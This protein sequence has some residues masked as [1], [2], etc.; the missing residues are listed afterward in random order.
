MMRV[1]GMMRVR[2]E[3]RWIRAAV[4]SILP[5]CERVLILDDHSEDGTPEICRSLGQR[6][7]VIPSPFD[8]L[9]ESRDKNYLLT[10]IGKLGAAWCLCIDGDEILAPDGS[11]RILAALE[12]ARHDCYALRI[13]FL[14]NGP[15]VVRVDGVYGQFSRPSLFR[16][17]T[18]A[19]F[20]VT[21]CGGHFHCGNVPAGLGAALSIEARLYHLGY[22][23]RADRLAKYGWYVAT[24]PGNELE[25]GYRHMVQGDLPEVPAHA[26]TRHAG[27]LRLAPI[28]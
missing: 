6:V 19:A 27:P 8:G 21:G 24:D 10:E 14:W 7:I 23:R 2:N 9:D 16:L 22:M 1:A 5:L 28:R 3:G 20:P 17:G 18:S 11:R 25:D 12:S 4:R 15:G 26:K 13:V